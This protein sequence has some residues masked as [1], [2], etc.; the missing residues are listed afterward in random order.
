[1][2]NKFKIG[3]KIKYSPYYKGVITAITSEGWLIIKFNDHCVMT[4]PDFCLEFDLDE[5][6]LPINCTCGAKHTSF[7]KHHLNWCD[8]LG[9][10]ND[11][12]K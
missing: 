4:L 9:N 10:K 1:M 11:T 8:S 12:S 6:K 7:S 2:R 5:Y 3:D